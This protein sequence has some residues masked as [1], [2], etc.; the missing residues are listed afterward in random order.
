MEKSMKTIR[1]KT[2]YQEVM[3][4]REKSKENVRAD[5]QYLQQFR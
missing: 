2:D 5:Q 1:L 4:V 3:Q